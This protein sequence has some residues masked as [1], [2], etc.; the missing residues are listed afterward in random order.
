MR[1]P[2]I[3]TDQPLKPGAELSLSEQAA[4]HV[5]RVLRLRPGAQVTLFNGDG[6]EF[7]ATVE[8]VSKKD[9]RVR[10]GEARDRDVES[11][12][13]LTLVQ[14]ISKGDRM[15]LTVQKAV[16]LGV[17]KLIPVVSE[18]TVVQLKGDREQRRMEHWRSIIRHACEQCGRNILPPMPDPVDLQDW[19]DRPPQGTGVVLDPTAGQGLGRLTPT[20]G[21]LVL[22][23]GP[24][25]G[26]APRELE[27][28]RAA[29]YQGVT[30]G[31]RIMRTETAALAAL[32]VIQ[33]LWGDLRH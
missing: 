26:L 19:L 21:K 16:E 20:D 14:C 4:T 17:T 22:L 18:R 6:G 12:L 24:E 7:D 31:P 25:G 5:A 32:A 3:H 27:Q 9:V 11:P 13:D 10:V 29:G 23:I 8:L 30:M 15:D 2:R 28:V 1:I 33:S